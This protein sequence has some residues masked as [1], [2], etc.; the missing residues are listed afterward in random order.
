MNLKS[1]N[2]LLP[3]K[4]GTFGEKKELSERSGTDACQSLPLAVGL[5]PINTP[6]G[7]IAAGSGPINAYGLWLNQ[8]TPNADDAPRPNF[9]GGKNIAQKQSEQDFA[10]RNMQTPM[11]SN[12]EE[13]SHFFFGGSFFY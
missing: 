6:T 8:F 3:G 4:A 9:R 10:Q 11:S 12:K 1:A 13:R 5:E 7:A 2:L